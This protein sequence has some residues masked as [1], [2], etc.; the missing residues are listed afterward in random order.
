[1][2][3]EGGTIM[4]K[5]EMITFMNEH[6]VMHLAT[7]EGNVPRVRAILMYKADENGIVFHTANT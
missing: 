5:E 3:K 1:M 7:V 6:P 4:T 2:K